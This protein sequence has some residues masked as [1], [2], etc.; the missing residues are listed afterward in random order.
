MNYNTHTMCVLDDE[1]LAV[2][3]SA[4]PADAVLCLKRI[5]KSTSI[6]LRK[7]QGKEH[8]GKITGLRRP[9]YATVSARN[10][11]RHVQE[12]RVMNP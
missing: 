4:Q 11:V 9:K 6:L 7:W 3:G 8:P 12:S 1:K 5:E 10:R 2:M